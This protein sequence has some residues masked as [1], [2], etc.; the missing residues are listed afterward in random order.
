MH[1]IKGYNQLLIRNFINNTVH[2]VPTASPIVSI[3]LVQT[4]DVTRGKYSQ[5]LLWVFASLFF[6]V[7]IDSS[8]I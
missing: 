7:L 2:G 6:R 3:T 4:N 8:L 1:F 5:L